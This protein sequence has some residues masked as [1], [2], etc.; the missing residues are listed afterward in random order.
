MMTSFLPVEE[1]P[2]VRGTFTFRR[3]WANVDWR[4]LSGVDVDK[5]AQTV[6]VQTLQNNILH[7]T[8]CNV[9]NEEFRN[10]DI[11]FIK[12]FRLAQLIIEYLL[13]TQQYLTDQLQ[14]LQEQLHITGQELQSTRIEVTTQSK[15]LKTVKRENR[16]R[17]KMIESYQQ[18]MNA[19]ASGLYPCHVCRR[20]FISAE[21]LKGHI[22]R[23]HTA[24]PKDDA[25]VLKEMEKELETKVFE[26][27]QQQLLQSQNEM[28]QEM[29]L[30]ESKLHEEKVKEFEMWKTQEQQRLKE[31]LAVHKA[32]LTTQLQQQNQHTT[33]LLQKTLEQAQEELKALRT[34]RDQSMEM[35][36]QATCNNDSTQLVDLQDKFHTQLQQSVKDE[37][38][39]WKKKLKETAK[40]YEDDLMERTR[41]YEEE[42]RESQGRI[43]VLEQ[44][45]AAIPKD[46]STV[47]HLAQ[48]VDQISTH[49][50]EMKEAQ[51]TCTTQHHI[52]VSSKP[53][54]LA[55]SDD[56]E[57]EEEDG[58]EHIRE[59]KQEDLLK[60][61]TALNSIVNEAMTKRGVEPS[62]GGLS[63]QKLTDK[64]KLLKQEQQSK[65][66]T[67]PLFAQQRSELE[68]QVEEQVKL[69]Y[70]PTVLVSPKKPPVSKL[71]ITPPIVTPTKSPQSPAK[72]PRSPT[73]SSRSPTELIL[74]SS[75][76]EESSD[77]DEE[78]TPV[79]SIAPKRTG[80]S[81][82]PT[83]AT[84]NVQTTPVITSILPLSIPTVSSAPFTPTNIPSAPTSA[85]F[86]ITSA[87]FTS[88]NTHLPVTSVRLPPNAIPV[89]P[90][91]TSVP[92]TVASTS[93]QP[94]PTLPTVADS[95]TAPNPIFDSESD[96]D[97]DS[98]EKLIAG[99]DVL[100]KA[101]S[102]PIKS[103]TVVERINRNKPRDGVV[104]MSG[105]PVMMIPQPLLDPLES[106]D[107]SDTFTIS[108][109]SAAPP[110]APPVSASK[111][112]SAQSVPLMSSKH[113]YHTAAV[114][115]S[116]S[117]LTTVT[118]D[119]FDSDIS[120]ITELK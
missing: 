80:A 47:K 91:A 61:K 93:V 97:D 42:L 38:K 103:V 4:A 21:F 78:E 84:T 53:S 55:S 72:S 50:T 46:T 6:D 109:L 79:V 66:Q 77:E 13:H 1:E 70:K 29:L 96:E 27:V 112:I 95:P 2:A 51:P 5:I 88:T 110:I 102:T 3:R 22:E 119:D 76:D 7:V 56:D 63:T 43:A 114:A 107:D 19:G 62:A 31:E 10:V 9:E 87:P 67:H 32:T 35:I 18:M 33:E 118:A 28:K 117:A 116:H 105:A 36:P 54:S 44:S 64:L 111:P 89:L 60:L 16:K 104:P 17:R 74:E 94:I 12:L 58:V 108:E 23:R 25:E 15:N 39:I 71:V 14:V 86:T 120:D 83:G 113:D 100:A 20:E 45:L 40:K 30:K 99:T 69:H 85:P 90:V 41:K 8:F 92:M 106:D 101:S 48:Q 81:G 11:N 52:I 73:K 68:K 65:A 59:K 34:S 115:S 49:L 24:K 57:E 37:R 26:K 98:I 82:L 75:S